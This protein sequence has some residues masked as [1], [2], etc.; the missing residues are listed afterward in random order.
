MPHIFADAFDRKTIVL[1]TIAHIGVG[2]VTARRG[3]FKAVC[4]QPVFKRGFIL[5][6]YSLQNDFFQGAIV[7]FIKSVGIYS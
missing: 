4:R 3:Y 6:V 7:Y 2:S 5:F 1:H